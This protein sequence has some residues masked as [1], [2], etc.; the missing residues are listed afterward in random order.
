MT[1]R[2]YITYIKTQ[3]MYILK[4]TEEGSWLKWGNPHYNGTILTYPISLRV[5]FILTLSSILQDTSELSLGHYVL[6]NG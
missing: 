3:I 5:V 1:F 6:S 2:E 4:K